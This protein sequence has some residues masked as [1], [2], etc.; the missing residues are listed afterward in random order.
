MGGGCTLG[1][2]S[3][4]LRDVDVAVQLYLHSGNGK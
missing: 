4:S 1:G 2:Y 3:I